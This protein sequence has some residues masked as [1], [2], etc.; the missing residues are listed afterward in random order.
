VN[1]KLKPE[2]EP[3]ALEEEL[4]NI[5]LP[6]LEDLNLE[7]VEL[8]LSRRRSVLLRLLIDRPQGGITIAECALVNRRLTEALDNS[9]LV[10]EKYLLEV[11]SPGLDRPLKSGKDFLRNRGRRVR[12]FLLEP[13]NNKMEIEGKVINVG[14]EAVII[15]TKNTNLE[16][17][18]KV[19]SQGKLIL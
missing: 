3:L 5:V 7:L 15:E 9:L 14:E 1:L 8:I 4:K 13:V 17:P 19:I 18:L 11:S 10:T 16:V 12:I 6:I 2:M